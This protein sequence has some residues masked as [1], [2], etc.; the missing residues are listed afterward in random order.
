MR[1]P[2]RS[3]RPT[4]AARP[5]ATLAL[6]IVLAAGAAACGDDGYDAAPT[7]PAPPLP[8]PTAVV[9]AAG[10]VGAR[11]AEF[12][13]LLGDPA[14]G[15]AAGQQPAGR[16][17]IGWDGAAANPF[18]NR[19]DFP[20]DFFNTTARNGV[21]FTTPGTGFRNDSTRFADVDASYAAEFATF[22]P[23]KIFAPVGSHVMDVHFRVAGEATPAAVTGFA[24]VFSDVEQAGATTIEYFDRDGRSLGRVAAPVRTDAVGLSLAGARFAQPIVARVRI[25]AGTGALGAGQKDVSAGGTRDLVVLDNFLFGEPVALAPR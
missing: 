6:P 7:A 19:N 18:N 3:P 9:V 15:A 10:D 5:L 13:T 8:Q 22:S 11:V 1:T 17:E 23:T 14:N 25:T 21:V 24:A 12:R 20:A 16:R 4:R 2:R